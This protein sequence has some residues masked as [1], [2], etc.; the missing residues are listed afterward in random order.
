MMNKL[1]EKKLDI[2][3]QQQ[4]RAATLAKK[5][6]LEE[7]VKKSQEEVAKCDVELGPLREEEGAKN[8]EK[9]KIKREGEKRMEKIDEKIKKVER[10]LGDVDRL[11][12]A[13]REY[14]EKGGDQEQVQLREAK[15][16]L[17][18]TK[19]PLL[20]KRQ[21]KGFAQTTSSIESTKRRSARLTGRLKK[22]KACWRM[23]NTSRW[24][25]KKGN[26]I[27]NTVSWKLRGTVRVEGW[28]R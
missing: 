4:E 1:T 5:E 24:T 28:R 22:L 17:P 9:A 21:G 25:G 16:V 19:K 12:I 10:Y 8:E 26:S 23:M 20:G 2:E 11:D 7:K 18:N 15:K 13:I 27:R 3:K 6:E 14:E